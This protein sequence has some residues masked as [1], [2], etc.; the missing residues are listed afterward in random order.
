MQY[1]AVYETKPVESLLDIFWETSSS[2]LI[3]DLNNAIINE[4]SAGANLTEFNTSNYTEALVLNGDVL[5]DP[6]YIINNFGQLVSINDINQTLALTEVFNELGT[7]VTSQGY[8]TLDQPD[9]N[10]NE[11]K[12]KATQA[13]Y[14]EFYFGEAD[15]SASPRGLRNFELRF[16]AQVNNQPL[17]VTRGL[18]LSNVSPEITSPAQ[19]AEFAITNNIENITTINCIN[20]ANNVNLRHIF[21][22]GSCTITSQT[23]FGQTDEVDYF[24]ITPGY[25]VVN[26]EAQF[27]LVNTKPG[28][29]P[30][31]RYQL[32]ICIEDAGGV[33]DRECIDIFIDFGVKIRN[34]KQYGISKKYGRLWYSTINTGNTFIGNFPCQI[35][36]DGWY[37][38]Y[39]VFEAYQGGNS[40][41]HGWYLYN[42]P[43][44]TQSRVDALDGITTSSL[45]G[46]DNFPQAYIV[47]QEYYASGAFGG[48]TFEYP[49]INKQDMKG[50]E[51]GPLFTD[52]GADGVI[53]IDFADVNKFDP[54]WPQGTGTGFNNSF[55]F[56]S[57][58]SGGTENDVVNLWKN[59][60]EIE[61]WCIT[62]FPIPP[63]TDPHQRGNYSKFP[64]PEAAASDNPNGFN[65]ASDCEPFSINGWDLQNN[66][67]TV[68]NAEVID[69][70]NYDQ[71][72]VAWQIIVV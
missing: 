66:D 50:T 5:Q 56:V 63:G 64:I 27:Q 21:A 24:A 49:G 20:G 13:Y 12:I 28:N 19:A 37:Q 18:Q 9:I 62:Q 8:F 51:Q 54:P 46:T 40:T 33:S 32:K 42:G 30:V 26:N 47:T 39:T 29:V 36:R 23:I 67:G 60:S 6:F 2:G 57:A 48:G 17:D 25:T 58:N 52:L 68:F 35:S 53:N 22:E 34:I 71:A 10:V 72:G 65:P 45:Y 14:D 55:R 61:E 43:W 7:D 38:F 59:S 11:F 15:G 1:L 3:S 44:S 70:T 4:S 41:A 31:E 69:G 16:E